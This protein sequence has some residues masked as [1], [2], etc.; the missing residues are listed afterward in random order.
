MANKTDRLMAKTA[1]KTIGEK[2]ATQAVQIAVGTAMQIGI[3]QALL[4][5][6]PS[7]EE[8]L[9]SITKSLIRSSV[10]VLASEVA[11]RSLLKR[12]DEFGNKKPS[13]KNYKFLTP[14]AKIYFGILAAAALS[15]R[16]AKLGQTKLK[17][18]KNVNLRHP[19]VLIRIHKSQ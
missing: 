11:S 1:S 7:K 4:G 15:P 17:D 10:N 6:T 8:I 3:S 2:A 18:L 14:E 13:S 9:K 12:Y 16:I 19:L 5:K